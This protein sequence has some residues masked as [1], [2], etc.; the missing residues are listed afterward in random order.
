MEAPEGRA[1]DVLTIK[2]VGIVA[3]QM[4]MS[5]KQVFLVAKR[6]DHLFRACIA[7]GLRPI[8]AHSS[9]EQKK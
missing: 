3:T 1:F 6:R 5:K 4:I 7:G 2:A 9:A 8:L